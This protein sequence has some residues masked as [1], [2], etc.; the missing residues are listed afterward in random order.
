MTAKEYK[1]F[2]KARDILEKRLTTPQIVS[3]LRVNMKDLVLWMM[4]GNTPPKVVERI[5]NA[6]DLV[7]SNYRNDRLALEKRRKSE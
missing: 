4:L 7:I 3:K 2:S 1:Q 6:R 5:L